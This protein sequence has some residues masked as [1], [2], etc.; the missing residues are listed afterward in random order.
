MVKS[1]RQ[2]YRVQLDS[3]L[4]DSDKE[5]IRSLCEFFH[6]P[7][8]AQKYIRLAVPVH[9]VRASLVLGVTVSN[10]A[11]GSENSHIN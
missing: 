10:M 3:A 9:I 11:L 6:R 5:E 7:N 4:S 2:Q 8:L 1:K